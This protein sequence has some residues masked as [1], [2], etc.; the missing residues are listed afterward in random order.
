MHVGESS[1][2]S[3]ITHTG[4]YHLLYINYA[5]NWI[6]SFWVWNSYENLRQG[7]WCVLFYDEPLAGG[8]ERVNMELECQWS[9]NVG[10]N[11]LT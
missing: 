8:R 10:L 3:I 5:K 6:I 4:F 9:W 7:L 2:R 11:S 1:F